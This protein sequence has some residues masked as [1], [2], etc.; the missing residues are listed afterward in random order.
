MKQAN[1][2]SLLFF[3]ASILAVLGS[4]VVPGS[5][6][7]GQIAKER[8]AAKLQTEC[9]A[10]SAYANLEA[11]PGGPKKFS[12]AGGHKTAFSSAPPPR[13]RNAKKDSLAPRDALEN[14][15]AGQRD[16]R[17]TRLKARTRALLI[18][19][20]GQ[21]ES[22]FRKTGKKDGDRPQ[23]VRRLAEGYVELESAANRDMIEANI[24]ADDAKN[25][26]QRNTYDESR[27]EASKAKQILEE[28]RKKAILFYRVMK[29]DYP[30]YSKIDE[31]LYYLAYE[32]EQANELDDARKVYFELIEQA[33]KS[34][35]VPNAYLAFG[36]LFFNEAMADPS[37]WAF[38]ASAYQKVTEYPAPEN[39]VWGY[40]RYKL[41]YVYWNSGEYAK[42]I[43]EFK[44]VIEYGNQYPKLPNATQLQKAARRDLVPVYAIAGKPDRAY[45]F[46]KPLS[47]D[48]GG[49]NE[50][51]LDLMNELG[52]AYVDTGHYPEGIRLYQD[53]MT[54]DQGDRFC[55]YQTQITYA[56]QALKAGDKDAVKKELEKQ[57]QVRAQFA[58]EGHS[59]KAVQA[60]HNLTAELL[61]ETGMSWHLEAV[62]TGGTRGTGDK[63]TMRLASY[64]YQKVVDNFTPEEFASFSFPR[65]VKEDW[66]NI[67][68]I[69]YAMADL[70]YVQERWE[71]CGPAFDAV[72][73][74]NPTGPEAP[75][76]AY[77][78]VLC[79]QKM[80]DQTHK[81]DDD[82][83]GQGLGPTSARAESSGA[84]EWEKFKPKDFTDMQKGMITAFNRYVCYI[85][86]PDGNKQ[87]YDQ[88]VEVKYARARTYFESQ[89]WEEAAIGFRDVA[90]NH[91]DH[92]SAIYAAQLYLESVN[93]MGS[94]TE[95]PRPACYRDMGDDVPAFLELFCGAGKYEE[96]KEQ[97]DLLTRIQCDVKRLRAEKMVAVADKGGASAFEKH[98]EAGDAYIEI[99]RTYGEQQLGAGGESQCGRMEE[100]LYN[101]AQAYQAGRL[102]A[103]AISVRMLLLNPQYKLN[104]TE[105]AQK[106]LYQ[107]GRNYQAIAVYDQAAKFL[108]RYAEATKYKGE[109]ADKAVSDS[110]VLNL[111]LGL[112]DEA[113]EAAS[114]FNRNY[115]RSKPAQ[116]GQIAFAIAAHYAE[117]REW[118]EVKKKLA[119]TAIGLIDRQPALDVQVQA[120]ALLAR[121]NA[122]M[123]IDNVAGREYGRV[124]GL[125]KDPKKAADS[126]GVEGEDAAGK[127]R[128]L[129]RALTAV[130]EALF[131]FAEKKREKVEAIQFP[132]Y[133][134]PGEP[135]AVKKHINTK[136]KAWV[137][138]KRPLVTE[139]TAE[140]KKIVDLQPLPPPSWVIAGGAR[141]GGMW[142]K[143]VEEFRAAPI[144][145]AMRRDPV[146]RT[147]YYGA[148]DEASEPLKQIGKGAYKT[149]LEYSVTYQY[150][151]EYSRSCE[152]WLA[153]NYKAEFHLIDEFRGSPNRVN[154]VLSERPN[155]L[156]ADGAPMVI[157]GKD[158]T[159][160][161]AEAK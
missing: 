94:K 108:M 17:Q 128:R 88:Y 77:A 127:Q 71:D 13:E 97:C 27:K 42:S 138:K 73:A 112:E 11:C 109:D 15:A 57:L 67:F 35:Y 32:Y 55:T 54:R 26:K 44:E 157:G 85:K 113:I 41:A 153:D 129:G 123:K 147:A 3:T 86:P 92:D 29:R 40:A 118:L 155:V 68:K 18:S 14:M 33:P 131:Y 106:A 141:V 19:E 111:G 58:K 52:L 4:W 79:Y 16:S 139:A 70:L 158:A 43:E 124:V 95:P 91:A 61:A 135:D 142:A 31:V 21:L 116:A 20:I 23:L 98:K 28:A 80:Y 1:K 83:K 63:E 87:A 5:A 126:V 110:V 159:P 66:P 37:K 25:K 114:S 30:D 103:K 152:E 69:K 65:I 10:P 134:G 9:I 82:K 161:K 8:G 133:K 149:C 45:N 38:A 105:L 143:F 96:N 60:C 72:V 160:A 56:T 101:A 146:V 12:G 84:G 99:W 62:G 6:E 46:F 53:L 130:G 156:Q 24:K 151:D 39:K 76:A 150:F 125:W 64:L 145:D 93:V 100:I 34:K 154:S 148:L 51:T 78:S 132:A 137:D 36:E 50:A 104:D 59:K 144:P 107:L 140:Y 75:E 90:L 119:G 121:A 89:H 2:L 102:L 74:D 115:G 117:K 22:L 136:V 120:H 48:K 49:E 47:G 122:E 7:A 81:G